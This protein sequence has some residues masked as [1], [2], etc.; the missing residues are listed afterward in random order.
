MKHVS[1]KEAK[2]RLPALLREVEN[3]E[4][5][6]ITRR[7]EPVADV[8]PHVRKK[9]GIDFE[10]MSRWKRA[11]GIDRV[12]GDPSPDFDDPFPEDFLLRPLP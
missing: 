3:G 11:R 10:A 5:V 2:D 7:G 12:F 9:G 6:V 8:V 4:H 1:I